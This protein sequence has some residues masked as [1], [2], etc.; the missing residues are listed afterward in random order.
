MPWTDIIFA[1]RTPDPLEFEC[2]SEALRC[3]SIVRRAPRVLCFFGHLLYRAPNVVSIENG[4]QC[5]TDSERV[6]FDARRAQR[7][8]YVDA[9]ENMRKQNESARWDRLCRRWASKHPPNRSPTT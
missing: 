5:V 3:V 6:T 2:S 8:Q 7:L 1:S 9:W 4:A